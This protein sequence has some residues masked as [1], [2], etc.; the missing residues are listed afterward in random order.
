MDDS[1]CFLALQLLLL[2]LRVLQLLLDT[3]KIREVPMH[4]KGPASCKLL[5]CGSCT[6]ASLRS[7]FLSRSPRDRGRPRPCC[8]RRATVNVR[9]LRTVLRYHD[10]VIC[11]LVANAV[12]LHVNSGSAVMCISLIVNST[13]TLPITAG[14]HQESTP[15]QL[16]PNQ[17]RDRCEKYLSSFWSYVN[18]LHKKVLM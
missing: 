15:S 11:S 16:E 13:V 14:K 9:D 2:L 1:V 4:L 5:L 10:C 7:T 18:V 3:F 8:R 6:V 12:R 17:E